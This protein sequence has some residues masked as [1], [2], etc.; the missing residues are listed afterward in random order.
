MIEKRE[1]VRDWHT[2]HMN[3]QKLMPNSKTTFWHLTAKDV[4]NSLGYELSETSLT[5][6]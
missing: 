4:L 1:G 5:V 6:T 2:N 3:V